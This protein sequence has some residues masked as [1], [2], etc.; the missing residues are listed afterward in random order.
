MPAFLAPSR[1]RAP[2]PGDGHRR[3]R[4]GG[5]T[6]CSRCCTAPQQAA[7]RCRWRKTARC[8]A[9]ALE[10]VGPSR[11]ADGTRRVFRA[12]ICD[13]GAEFSDE[14]ARRCSARAGRDEGCSTAAEAQRPEKGACE[15][16]HVEI[17]KAAAQG[18]GIQVRPAR[19]GRPGAGHVARELEP[20][21][22]RLRDARAPSG[23]MLGEGRGNML[24]AYGVGGRAR[25]PRPDAGSS[26]GRA[27]RAMP[28]W[29]SPGR[30]TEWRRADR[31][32]GVWERGAEGRGGRS[33]A[34]G[35]IETHLHRSFN[36]ENA[37]PGSR[38]GPRGRSAN[39]GNGLFAQC[40][41]LRSKINQ[42]VGTNL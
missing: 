6:A 39:C 5:L 27:Q 12:V 8:V 23:A 36:W 21:G 17:R 14:A 2:Q 25:R 9:D 19:P 18:A 41:R 37:A 29:P 33:M 20:R 40:V 30:K 15:R 42:N 31:P 10:G 38:M 28:R 3:G 24:D 1:T 4:P 35:P 13:N 7:A 22:A 16:N 26:R 32:A 11:G 34:T